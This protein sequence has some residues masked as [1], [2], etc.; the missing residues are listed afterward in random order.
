M[1]KSIV[2]TASLLSLALL[3]SG[4]FQSA[5]AAQTTGGVNWLDP[6]GYAKPAFRSLTIPTP[7]A[8]QYWV[9]LAGGSGSTCTATSPCTWASVQGK[10]GTQGGGAV[11]YIRNSGPIGSPTLYGTAGNEVVIKPWNDTT[12]ATITGRNNW[13]TRI[14]YVIFDGGP[15]LSIKFNNTA[16]A[17]FDPSIYFNAATAGLESHITFY[18]TQWTVPGMGENIAQ[19]GIVDNLNIINSEFQS[20]SS[21][22][23]NNQHHI[24]FS[25]ASNLL[26]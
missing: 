4:S 9:D 1:S 17:Q 16:N 24:Y 22:D 8:N 18:R 23:R 14:Q 11:I 2:R 13:T 12:P 19:W 6:L 21:T 3:S 5:S 26:R 10:P 7:G 25:G 20:G 15:N